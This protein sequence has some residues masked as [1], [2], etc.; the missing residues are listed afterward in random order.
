[1]HSIFISF[2]HESVLF[3]LLRV[4][5]GILFL[6]QGIDKVF[7]VGIYKVTDTFQFELGAIKFPRWFLFISAFYT[8]YVELI[9]GILLIAGLFKTYAL[10]LLGLDL[11]LVT[12]AFSIISPLWDMKFILPRLALLS[13]LLYLPPKWDYFSLDS[14]LVIF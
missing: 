5:L 2:H 7:K 12:I 4:I 6:F 14:L 9:G 13:I 8:S 10:Y 3:F 11:I 1:M